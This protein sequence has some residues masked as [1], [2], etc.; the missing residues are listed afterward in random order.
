MWP[1]RSNWPG[2]HDRNSKYDFY[3]AV[4]VVRPVLVRRSSVPVFA[5]VVVV[6]LHI[7]VAVDV[8]FDYSNGNSNMAAGGS[9]DPLDFVICLTQNRSYDF[10]CRVAMTYEYWLSY[11]SYFFGA[12]LGVYS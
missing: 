10:R 8:S 6:L 2:R 4:L 3:R 9:G 12:D 11:H 7:F 1:D 5:K